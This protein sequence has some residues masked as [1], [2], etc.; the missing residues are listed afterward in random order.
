MPKIYHT[1]PPPIEELDEVLAFIYTGPCKP[2]KSDFERIPLLVRCKK[3]ATALEWLE[4]NHIDYLDLN[5]SYDNLEKYPENEP[6]VVVDYKKS[7]ENKDPESTVINDMEDESGVEIGQYFTIPHG[8][9]VESTG[10]QWTPVDS[11]WTPHGLSQK[12]V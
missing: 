12:S 9:H 6:P 8:V 2:T 7:F 3:V 1:L 10:L 5:I 4:L 11:M